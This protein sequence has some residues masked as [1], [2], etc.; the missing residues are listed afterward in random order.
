MKSIL[1][2]TEYKRTLEDWEISWG[3]TNNLYRHWCKQVHG[4]NNG[5]IL[6]VMFNPGS[7]KG[8]GIKLSRDTTLR[9]L[10]E[11]FQG[12]GLN[13][14]IINLFDFSAS[15][16]DEFFNNWE[17]RDGEK[18]IFDDLALSDFK[19]VLYAYGDYENLRTYRS[20]II[21]R[22]DFVRNKSSLLPEISLCKNISGTPRHPYS[23]QLKKL[24]NDIRNI[25]KEFAIHDV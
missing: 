1:I 3:S 22:I 14:F 24:K 10:R 12:T 11:V 5:F 20:I 6:V 15:T 23:W 19:G 21:D 7:L 17:K 13:P 16:T 9:I 2:G 8:Q 18:L 25:I 4:L